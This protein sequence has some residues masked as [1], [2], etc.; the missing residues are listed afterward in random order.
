M[1]AG[2]AAAR[3]LRA[4][5]LV[6]ALLLG[7]LAPGGARAGCDVDLSLVDFG[8]LDP[9][10][11]GEIAGRVTVECDAPAGFA[12]ALTPGF[13]SYAERRMRGPG[14]AE[15]RYNLYTDPARRVVWGDGM[16]G[17]GLVRGDTGGRRRATVPVYGHVPRGQRVPAG[18][19]A[20][21]LTV[22]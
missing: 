4:A 3:P 14:G 16:G 8:R 20:D 7:A 13:G 6:G 10:R 17:T 12:L 1:T 21:Q 18:A 5:L 11:G 15:L 9:A 2:A 22:N 19:Y